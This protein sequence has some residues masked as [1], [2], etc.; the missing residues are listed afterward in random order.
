MLILWRKL[1]LKNY[2]L[3]NILIIT[4]GILIML[5]INH[6]IYVGA[7]LS[8]LVILILIS[9]VHKRNIIKTCVEF[10]IV[11]SLNIIFQLVGISILKF[12]VGNYNN[13][14]YNN[15]IVQLSILVFTY[16]ICNV[17]LKDKV[18]CKDNVDK[19]A[20]G[21][22]VVNLLSYILILKTIWNFNESIILKNMLKIIFL[23]SS[24]FIFNI[25]MYSYITKIEK[26]KDNAK[27]QEQYN[28]ILKSLT[29]E[30]RQ[31]QHDFRN[32]LN[33]INGLAQVSDE[34]EVKD[35]IKAYIGKLSNSMMDIEKIIYIDNTI[36]RAIIYSKYQ[37]AKK[38]NVGFCYCITSSLE[39]IPLEDF[40]MSE[41]LTNL[42]DNAF[43]AVACQEDQLIEVEIYEEEGNSIIE[44][45]N[46]GITVKDENIEKIFERGFS[47]K[48]GK[49]RGYGLYNV[50]RIVEGTGGSA[51]IYIEDNYTV[52]KLTIKNKKA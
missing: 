31:R 46:S 3:K 33:I 24:I 27:T 29:E 21:F 37:E 14:Y 4:V 44:V 49:G 20:V 1:G 40:Q 9:Y 17:V 43:E 10:L 45:R 30:I 5:L 15:L 16:V 19:K 41:I 22:F 48:G 18:Y 2:W 8:Q 32:H 13:N 11:L 7:I 38:R 39:N 34:K 12:L 6:N 47:T 51:K 36:V 35:K 26:Q 28:N 52:F 23:I 25:L 42:I 50:R